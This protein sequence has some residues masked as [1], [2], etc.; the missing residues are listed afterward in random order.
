M[1]KVKKSDNSLTYVVPQ[2]QQTDDVICKKQIYNAEN[3]ST[4][5]ISWMIL[6]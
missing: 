2:G 6:K 1:L 4:H 3:A 5:Q